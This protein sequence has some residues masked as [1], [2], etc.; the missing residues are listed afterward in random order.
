MIVTPVSNEAGHIHQLL[1]CKYF[2]ILPPP[3]LHVLAFVPNFHQPI[4]E[5]C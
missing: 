3:Y 5:T 2:A 1:L 4:P